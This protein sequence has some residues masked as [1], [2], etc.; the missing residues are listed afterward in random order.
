MKTKIRHIII[1]TVLLGLASAPAHAGDEAVAAIGGFIAGV[2][3]GSAIN[4]HHD[5]YSHVSY[6]SVG[7]RS[8][9]RVTISHPPRG[10]PYYNHRDPRYRYDSRLGYVTN[11]RGY[12]TYK[13]VKV[14]VPGYWEYTHSRHGHRI[15]VWREGHYRYETR[16][17]WIPKKT[18]RGPG[19]CR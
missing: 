1:A 17:V 2:I 5:H 10:V 6:R 13:K 8:G 19:Y 11:S 18:D 3:T 12:Y 16:K 9:S 14:W 15:K 7:H 4:D